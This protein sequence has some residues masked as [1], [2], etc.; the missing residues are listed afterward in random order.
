MCMVLQETMR[1]VASHDQL[2]PF[3]LWR[4]RPQETVRGKG[5]HILQ[6]EQSFVVTLDRRTCNPKTR[7]GAPCGGEL[8]ASRQT[9]EGVQITPRTAKTPAVNHEERRRFGRSPKTNLQR[10]RR[11]ASGGF[12]GKNSGH[13]KPLIESRAATAFALFQ[14]PETLSQRSELY[15]K[16]TAEWGSKQRLWIFE[17]HGGLMAKRWPLPSLPPTSR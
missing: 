7:R 5:G 13:L 8:S 2:H 11:R 3:I 15:T 14:D 4:A 1:Y 17:M 16:P 9:L 12:S 6:V 10:A